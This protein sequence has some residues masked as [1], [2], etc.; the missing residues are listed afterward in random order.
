MEP[1]LKRRITSNI[2]GLPLKPLNLQERVEGQVAA[3]GETQ[4]LSPMGAGALV[5]ATAFAAALKK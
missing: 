5:Q 3:G 2:A 4:S 1:S